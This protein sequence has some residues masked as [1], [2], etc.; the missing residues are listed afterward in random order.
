[1]SWDAEDMRDHRREQQERRAERL[2][3]RQQAILD[4]QNHGYL[5]EQLTEFQ[6]RVTKF[7]SLK[8]VDIYPIHL[9]YHNITDN[10]RGQIRGIRGMIPLLENIFG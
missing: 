2:P 3:D 5:V 7:G 10:R 8:R 9:K 1:M 6:F 4:L